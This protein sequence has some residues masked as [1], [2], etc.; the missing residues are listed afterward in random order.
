MSRTKYL[1]ISGSNINLVANQKTADQGL[2]DAHAALAATAASLDVSVDCHQ[3]KHKDDMVTCLQ[4]APK[5][6]A[7]V[8]INTAG[9][10]DYKD[11]LCRTIESMLLPCIEV[12]TSHTDT[13]HNAVIAPVCMGVIGGFGEQSYSLGLAA[14]VHLHKQ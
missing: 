10:S 7:G 13:H 4:N 2:Q 11:A 6:Y 3:F 1:V 8:M 14:L 5:D 9:M 12:F